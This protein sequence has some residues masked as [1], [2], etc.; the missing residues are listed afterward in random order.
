MTPEADTDS[1]NEVTPEEKPDT[2]NEVENPETPNRV[3]EEKPDV[4]PGM[5]EKTPETN[6]T[7]KEISTQKDEKKESQKI[8]TT[9][10]RINEEKQNTDTQRFDSPHPAETLKK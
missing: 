5:P 6:I 4:A 9:I 1:S 2:D 7:A 3:P 8:N 10:Q